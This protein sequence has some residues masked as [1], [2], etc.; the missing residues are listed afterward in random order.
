MTFKNI[1]VPTDFGEADARALDMA[2]AIAAKFESHLTLLHA[3]GIPSSAVSAY[4]D[5]LV[6]PT[7]DMEEL[8]RKDLQA[9]V[10]GAKAR[11]PSIE[12]VLASEEP[13]QAILDVAKSR[14]ADLIVMGTHGRRG[15]ARA[16][17]GSVAE[18]VVRLSPIPVLTVGRRENDKR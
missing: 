10:A 6:L 1:L 4:A 2:I 18:K 9:V 16:L 15:L 8:A 17:I 3:N 13:F 14:D 12:G 5:G 7:E 11:Y